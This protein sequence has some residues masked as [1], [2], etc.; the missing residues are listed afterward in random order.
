MRSG[1]MCGPCQVATSE[2][3]DGLVRDVDGAQGSDD[4][5]WVM[6]GGLYADAIDFYPENALN[7]L[8]HDAN[9]A[10][11]SHDQQWKISDELDTD[12]IKI[13]HK[14]ALDN[15]TDRSGGYQMND[16]SLNTDTMSDGFARDE[17]V[18]TYEDKVTDWLSKTD[19]Y[20]AA[21]AEYQCEGDFLRI[22]S[23]PGD[24]RSTTECSS[25][26]HFQA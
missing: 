20:E 8:V 17:S 23:K 22:L 10:G 19:S 16:A 24:T 13:Y 2:M 6:S 12:T 11:A 9:G 25:C 4:Q 7:D 3:L 1:E 14:N 21:A 26:K 18:S 5:P 15:F